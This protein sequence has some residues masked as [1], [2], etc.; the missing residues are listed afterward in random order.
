MR[1]FIYD[2][3]C[4]H[5]RAVP[6]TWRHWIYMKD[7]KTVAVICPSCHRAL[8][9]PNHRVSPDGSVRPSL[10]CTHAGCTFHEFVTLKDYKES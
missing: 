1:V 9:L 8:C 3:D 4:L 6:G 5:G 10:V 2:P 7:Q